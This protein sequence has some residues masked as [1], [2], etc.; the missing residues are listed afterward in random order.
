MEAKVDKALPM[1]LPEQRQDVVK[2]ERQMLEKGSNG[3]LFT[4]GTGTGKTYVG[5]G[6]VKRMADSGKKNIMVVVPGDTIGR[7]WA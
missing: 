3:F 1:L 5:M 7:Q 2:A 4:N 6:L